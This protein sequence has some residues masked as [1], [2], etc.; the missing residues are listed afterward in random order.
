MNFAG[1][2][3]GIARTFEAHPVAAPLVTAGALALAAKAVA[4]AHGGVASA[5]LA[6]AV[7][8]A[9]YGAVRAAAVLAG[10]MES[11]AGATL[12]GNPNTIA[13]PGEHPD[14]PARRPTWEDFH[15]LPNADAR[16]DA[17]KAAVEAW[18]RKGNVYYLSLRQVIVAEDEDLARKMAA[19]ARR[20][21]SA[22]RAAVLTAAGKLSRNALALPFVGTAHERWQ[23]PDRQTPGIGAKKETLAGWRDYYEIRARCAERVFRA[24]AAQ[25]QRP[26]VVAWQG[27]ADDAATRSAAA[28]EF[29]EAARLFGEANDP[30]SG[31]PQAYR[32]AID[33]VR[34]GLATLGYDDVTAQ[35]VDGFVTSR[36][37]KAQVCA[38]SAKA[39]AGAKGRLTTLQKLAPLASL[40]EAARAGELNKAG[41]RELAKLRK[42]ADATMERWG[43]D[44]SKLTAA[45]RAEYTRMRFAAAGQSEAYE[46]R[47]AARG[48]P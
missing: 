20:S 31:T 19:Q 8:A 46:A 35:L 36:M 10:G 39:E 27:L 1:A 15:D 25:A 41:E 13:L 3:R 34:K 37:T 2:W 32:Q 16:G 9:G 18:E 45:E 21:D 30:N 4:P 42:V 48:M 44:T 47:K 14:V 28:G 43:R 7:G 22:S 26:D 24:K 11:R 12:R 5:L 29:D 23:W 40:E 38:A 33:A 6:G 17:Y